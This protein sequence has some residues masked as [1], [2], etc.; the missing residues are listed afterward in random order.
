[1]L[2]AYMYGFGLKLCMN[3]Q[4]DLWRG[5]QGAGYDEG[6]VYLSSC[7]EVNFNTLQ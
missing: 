1:M 2:C 3:Y 7:E 6:L 4:S 5:G